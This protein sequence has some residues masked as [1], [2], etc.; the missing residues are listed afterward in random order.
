MEN[1]LLYGVI[2][3]VLIAIFFIWKKMRKPKGDTSFWKGEV[4][5]KDSQPDN[6]YLVTVITDDNQTITAKVSK[7]LWSNLERGDRIE[8]RKDDL[9]PRKT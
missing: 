2:V 8:K 7:I 3:V 6:S 5:G 9:Y 1:Y 4:K